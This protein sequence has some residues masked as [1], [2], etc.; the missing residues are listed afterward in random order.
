M[1]HRFCKT[2]FYKHSKEDRV[3]KTLM[4]CII[5]LAWNLGSTLPAFPGA[6]GYGSQTP[7]GRGGKVIF[8]TNTN[9]TGAGSFQN[10]LLTPGPRTI[11]FRTSGVVQLPDQILMENANLAYVTIAG[12]TSPGG[13]TITAAQNT[14]IWQYQAGKCHDEIWRFLRFRV[15]NASN[16]HSFEHY[17]DSCFILDHCDFSGGTDECLDICRCHDFTYQWCNISNSGPTGQVYGSLHGYSPL[18][19]LSIHHNLWANHQHRA[20]VVDFEVTAGVT[21]FNVDLRNNII[22]N[23]ASGYPTCFA[24]PGVPDGDTSNGW[25]HAN[26]VGNNYLWGPDNS[27]SQS[28]PPDYILSDVKV[29]EYDTYWNCTN[30]WAGPDT[31]ID[32]RYGRHATRAPAAFDMPPITT[33]SSAQARTDV[34]AKVGAFPRDSMSIKTIAD[35]RNKTHT[36]NLWGQPLIASGPAAP[37]DADSDGIPDFWETAM[38]LNPNDPSDGVKDFDGTGYANV[39]KYVNDLA[40]ARLCE[41]YY[42][43]AYPIPSDWPDY[44]PSCCKQRPTATEKIVSRANSG[45]ALLISPNP[46]ASGHLQISLSNTGRVAGFVRIIN[47]AGQLVATL[48]ASRTISWNGQASSGTRVSAGVY[49]VQ[50]TEGNK[51]IGQKRVMVAR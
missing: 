30:R 14:P 23:I 11:I 10:A 29:Y 31:M 37:A 47:A 8:V 6:E 9:G 7:G 46:F 12:Q 1:R 38:G 34:L 5:L 24:G 13:I 25:V 20:P 33:V 22:Y 19:N 41:D 27:C 48:P 45:P 44:N 26:M 35:V 51:L 17:F 50:W 4:T 36:A 2:Q 49:V 32:I 40:L 21:I 43:S 42:Y 39:E 28:A 15:K 3:I 18:N 16:D